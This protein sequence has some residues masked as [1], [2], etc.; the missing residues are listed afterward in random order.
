MSQIVLYVSTCLDTT[1]HID[2]SSTCLELCFK[3]NAHILHILC[4][5]PPK[6]HR[7]GTKANQ[8]LLSVSE[9]LH[10]VCELQ[11]MFTGVNI[12]REILII[13]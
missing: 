9:A 11:Y 5:C 6:L 7:R 3:T 4:K 12:Q 8:N 10:Y 1:H 2:I 13:T